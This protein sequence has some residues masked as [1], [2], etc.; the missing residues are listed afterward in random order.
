FKGPDGGRGVAQMPA[1]RLHLP[2]RGMSCAG[3]AS[4]IEPEA[5]VD[6]ERQAR[7]A[8]IRTLS[9]KLVAGL[10]LSLA[11]FVGSMSMLFPWAPG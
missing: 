8:E 11:I 6:R 9:R 2:I 7:A 3:C 1:Q 10:V 4:R 5:A